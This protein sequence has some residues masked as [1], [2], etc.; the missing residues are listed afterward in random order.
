MMHRQTSVFF[1]AHLPL[2]QLDSNAR[3]ILERRYLRHDDAG[4]VCETPEE[5]FWRVAW[6]IALADGQYDQ[7]ADIQK[8]AE[9]FYLLM[10]ECKFL[11][12]S[13]CLRG[14]GRELQQLFGCFVLP[15]EDS[16]DSIFET[17]KI[18]A[19]IHKTG[20]GTGFSFSRLR[21][22]N[23]PVRTTAGC[24]SGPISFMRVFNAATSEITQGG[25]RMGAN[26]GILRVDH[27]DIEEFIDC[28]LNDTAF[29][30]FNISVAINDAFVAAIENNGD[31]DIIDPR[32]NTIVGKKNARFIF[33]K[34]VQNAWKNGDPGIIFLDRIN[35]SE[36]NMTPA[37]GAI[38]STNPCGEQPL[39][40]YESCVLGSINLAKFATEAGID[41]DAL[42]TT[43]HDA[44][45]FLDNV[46]DMNHYV[47]PKIEEM[48]KGLRRFGLG[49]MGFADMLIA[50]SIPYNSPEA[51]ALAKKVMQFVDDQARDASEQMALKRGAFPFF[52]K[53]LYATQNRPLIRNVARTTIAPTGTISTIA[54]CSS[55]IEPIFALVHRRKSL[56][57]QDGSTTELL[58]TNKQF[59]ARARAAGVYSE[60]LMA[61]IFEKGSLQGI[62]EIPA[63][64]KKVF[65]T[66]HDIEPDAHI[67][68]QA[69]FQNHVNN[70]VSKTINFPHNA[71]LEDVS[72][73]YLLAYHKGCKG[74]T[75]Y[76]DGSRSIQVLT[77]GSGTKA[78]EQPVIV[79]NTTS[80]LSFAPATPLDSLHDYMDRCPE[81]GASIEAGEGCFKCLQCGHSRCS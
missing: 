24:S 73:A 47:I 20:G 8:T 23:A 41:W 2:A 29:T 7:K 59:E 57:K 36:S 54:G 71:S 3:T 37:I 38:E 49:V 69:A 40:P 80:E 65:V 62:A 55:G 78:V 11:P 74:I 4:V 15:I 81:C 6:N 9:K 67:N 31:Y 44:A 19:L 68:I 10:A 34:I 60:E 50:L 76:R 42:K 39:L 58:V 5:L 13:P 17:L 18:T 26:M 27:P 70:A 30:S 51:V 61:K 66:S 45:H 21:P 79:K 56:W 12:N 48:T 32:T 25:V 77:V 1:P 16:L 22:R 72:R 46:I 53:S 63:E 52:K 28:K 75:I 35:A 43:I 64:L 14:A 33:E